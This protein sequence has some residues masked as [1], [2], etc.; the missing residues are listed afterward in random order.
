MPWETLKAGDVPL[1][2]VAVASRTLTVCAP[3]AVMVGWTKEKPVVVTEDPVG[4][5][6]QVP[7]SSMYW[8]VGA[9]VYP[10][11]VPVMVKGKRIS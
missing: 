6:V 9:V 7:E 8:R 10:L 11:S 5:A 2:P 1:T 4:K 3:S